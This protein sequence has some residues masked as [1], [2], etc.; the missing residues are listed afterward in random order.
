MP[1]CANTWLLRDVLRTAWNFSGYVTSDTGAVI[2]IFQGECAGPPAAPCSGGHHFAKNWTDAVIK[3]LEAGCDIESHGQGGEPAG[4]LPPLYVAYAPAAVRSGQL[5][6]SRLDDA[7]RHALSMRFELGLFDPIEDQPYWHVPPDVV[8]SRAH[9]ELALDA[10]RQ[11]L[12]LLTNGG[13]RPSSP[14]RAGRAQPVLPFLGGARTAVIGPHAN[15]RDAILGNY[16]GQICK[17]GL[18]D[19]DCV[20]SVY[21]QVAKLN[22]VAAA[23]R[24]V[25]PYTVNATGV[26]VNSS[27]TSGIQAALDAAADVDVIVYVGGLDVENC[28]REGKDRHEVGL[29]GQQPALLRALLALGKPLALVLFHGGIMTLPP[30]IVA[31]PLLAVVSAGYPGVHGSQAISEALFDAA[32]VGDGQAAN[33]WGRTAVTWYTEE[34]WQDAAYDMLSFEM[35]APP[36]RSYRYYTGVPQWRFG[37][38]LSYT[39]FE[40][41]VTHAKAGGGH[42]TFTVANQM[43][44]GG[45]TGDAIVLLYVRPGNGTVP[46]SAPASALRRQLVSFERLASIRA[47]SRSRFSF[48]LTVEH[49]T[50]VDAHGKPLL[51]P[52]LYELLAS[53]GDEE[54]DAHLAFHCDASGLVVITSGRISLP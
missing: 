26:A 33:R 52:G 3:A 12:V 47:A 37:H 14:G 41:S 54:A 42:C 16:I 36:G 43:G 1:S 31:H 7:L 32:G 13:S 4:G 6:E 50:L 27:D 35:A 46:S 11:G 48:E 28:E 51:Y 9:H 5:S 45:R 19:R 25:K 2:D 30:D 34:G 24:G 49:V 15:D 23:T 18:H 39:P 44:A 22:A 20:P 10:T 17:G 40:L 21:E 8:G 53:L 29:P 38:G